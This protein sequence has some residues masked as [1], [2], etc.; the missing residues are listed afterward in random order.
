VRPHIRSLALL[1]LCLLG[2]ALGFYLLFGALDRKSPEPSGLKS[3]LGAQ[4]GGVVHVRSGLER[5]SAHRPARPGVKPAS[6]A[7]I[8]GYGGAAQALVTLYH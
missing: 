3:L 6:E 2:S 8:G 4:K 7:S 1:G 5:T